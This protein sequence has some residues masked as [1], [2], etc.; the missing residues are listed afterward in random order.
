MSPS[1]LIPQFGSSVCSVLNIYEIGKFWT[2][3]LGN[4]RTVAKKPVEYL[5]RSFVLQ[6]TIR[7]KKP[8]ILDIWGDLSKII[9]IFSS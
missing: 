1:S 3:T 2:S 9:Q 4:L 5:R 8:L 7:S 6:Y